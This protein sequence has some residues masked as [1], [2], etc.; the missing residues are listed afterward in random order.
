MDGAYLGGSAVYLI[1]A[2]A[3]FGIFVT[4]VALGAFGA[5]QFLGD[6][7]EMIMLFAASIAFT[8]AILRREAAARRTK[9]KN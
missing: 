1:I 9:D 5:T 4:N 2:A 3:L 8:V 6:V 7:G